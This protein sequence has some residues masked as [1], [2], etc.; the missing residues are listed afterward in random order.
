MLFNTYFHRRRMP[1]CFPYPGQP[2]VLLGIGSQSHFKI[3]K[4]LQQL[5]T[6]SGKFLNNLNISDFPM[7]LY[8]L[9][10]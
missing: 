4:N 10:I 2:H 6:L 7:G 9:V 5:A 3:D 1:F 8:L